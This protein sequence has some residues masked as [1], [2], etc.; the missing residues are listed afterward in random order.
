MVRT[1]GYHGY[2]ETGG[3]FDSRQGANDTPV[4]R[5]KSLMFVVRYQRRYHCKPFR[6]IGCFCSL[7]INFRHP[8][9]MCIYK[10]PLYDLNTEEDEKVV[11]PRV[12]IRLLPLYSGRC[13]RKQKNRMYFT[14]KMRMNALYV[15]VCQ[16]SNSRA[17]G[18][19]RETRR[20]VKNA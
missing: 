8:V 4:P 16:K 19:D 20:D 2:G 9:T 5:N 7:F 3:D 10:Y 13:V 6:T 15:I 11:C 12:T 14:R 18:K 17:A 1:V